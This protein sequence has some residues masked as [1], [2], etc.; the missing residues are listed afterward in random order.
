LRQGRAR[1]ESLVIVVLASLLV[2]LRRMERDE[3]RP[4]RAAHY[5][6]HS[7]GRMIGST[8]PAAYL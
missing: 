4:I 1:A 5:G 8:D 6:V 7:I 2:F 3:T